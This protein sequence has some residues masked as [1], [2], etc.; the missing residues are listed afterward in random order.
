MVTL[1]IDGIEVTVAEG[2][3]LVEAAA[4]ARRDNTTKS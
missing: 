4:A 3:N 1:A 2:T